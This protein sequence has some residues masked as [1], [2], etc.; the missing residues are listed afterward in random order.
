MRVWLILR[1]LLHPLRFVGERIDNWV[2][3]RVK[4]QAGPIH[5]PRHRVYILPTRFGYAFA[6]MCLVM[7]LGSMNYS[8]SMGF[9][10]TFLLAG[11]GL[12]AMHHTHGNLVN[13]RL[14]AGRAQPVFAGETAH[15]EVVVENP[16]ARA[17]YALELSWPRDS[18]PPFYAD[19]P[20]LDSV[21]MRIA[22]PA[23]QRGWLSARVFAVST[24]FPLGLFHAWTWAELDMACLV[25]PRPAAPGAEPPPTTGMGGEQS[26]ARGGQDEFA[27]L[28][29][30]QRGD[31]LRSIHWKSL[32]KLRRPMVKQFTETLEH[33]LWLDWDTLT[34]LDA[35]AR[36]S[37]LTRW[38]LEAEAETRAY[39]LRIPGTAIPPARGEVHQ[40]QCL[41]A[42]ALHDGGGPGR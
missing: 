10:L 34:G 37:Q 21:P 11:L 32:P 26:S 28:R 8:N 2:M 4:R 41:K 7:L 40:H 14:S 35:E 39:G 15:F 12:V 19:V 23:T 13:I 20:A 1:I 36:L 16:A 27:G 42:L 3:R 24:E 31:A 18:Q 30:Y 9:A 29:G 22:L 6:F 17:R 38:V 5:V 25:Y 33:E